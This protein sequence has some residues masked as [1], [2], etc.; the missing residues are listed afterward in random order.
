MLALLSHRL[1]CRC[2][3]F[4]QLSNIVLY[5]Y[6]IIL[7]LLTIFNKATHQAN[8]LLP[9]HW[10]SYPGCKF[11]YAAIKATERQTE[12]TE[13]LS[14]GLFDPEESGVMEREVGCKDIMYHERNDH[15]ECNDHDKC[16]EQWS[17]MTNW[18]TYLERNDSNES[19]KKW[20][21]LSLMMSSDA[22]DVLVQTIWRRNIRSMGLWMSA[23]I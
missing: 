13:E 20:Q 22:D 12:E 6:R 3:H 2:R 17:T 1:H 4:L 18:L 10:R 7:P 15:N 21:L 16:N 8:F 23:D 11:C 14:E 19:N 9:Q 5:T